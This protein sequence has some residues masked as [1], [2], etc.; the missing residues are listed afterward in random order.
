MAY[1]FGVGEYVTANERKAE[2]LAVRGKTLIGIV[3]AECYVDG[4]AVRRWQLDG[5]SGDGMG[6]TLLP[7]KQTRTLWLN[8]Y[9]R[10]E[11]R[12]VAHTSKEQASL[13][14]MGDRIACKEITIEFTP[15]E[16]LE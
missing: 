10:E 16:G 4:F 6:C 14:S 13:G 7:P 9:K 12:D 15:G 8:I 11:T 1:Q 5:T 3:Y 2:V